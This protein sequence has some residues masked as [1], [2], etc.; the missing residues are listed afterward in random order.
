LLLGL[1]LAQGVYYALRHLGI[2]WLFGS[3]QDTAWFRTGQGAILVIA[4][5]IVSLLFASIVA[6]SGV[7]RGGLLGSLLGMIN[8]GCFIAVEFLVVGPPEASLLISGPILHLLTGTIGG[9]IGRLLWKPLPPLPRYDLPGSSSNLKEKEL[10]VETERG[11]LSWSRIIA[12]GVL[13]FVGT[14]W[15]HDIRLTMGKYAR[16]DDRVFD[17]FI[18]WEVCALIVLFG[19]AFAGANTRRGFMHGFLVSLLACMGL[20]VAMF[21]K[22][23]RFYPAHEFWLTEFGIAKPQTGVSI[24]VALFAVIDTMLLATLGGWL[25]AQLLQPTSRRRES[26]LLNRV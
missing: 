15:A 25:G 1:I 8:I 6:S 14:V 4:S 12:G 18:T 22:E 3:G 2:A 11:P 21:A 7:P 24:P 26:T 5:Q 10:V 13:V 20:V 19:G 23:I 16:I 9:L 17:Q